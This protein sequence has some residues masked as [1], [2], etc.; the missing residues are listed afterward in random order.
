MPVKWMSGWMHAWF[1]WSS[2]QMCLTW[3][4]KA[5]TQ[6]GRAQFGL[7]MKLKSYLERG[8]GMV[9]SSPSLKEFKQT[10]VAGRQNRKW[11]GVLGGKP[12][13]VTSPAPS[14]REVSRPSSLTLLTMPCRETELILPS[15]LQILIG[16][17]YPW[18]LWSFVPTSSWRVRKHGLDWYS[19]GLSCL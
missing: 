9:V 11:I 1:R 16:T 19:Q 12:E 2:A 13:H 10:L 15:S 18:G 3:R 4:M 6:T 8:R 17:I 7:S 14:N 5:K